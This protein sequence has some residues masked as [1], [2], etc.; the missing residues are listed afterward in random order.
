MKK[1]ISYIIFLISFIILLGSC[2]HDP[3]YTEVPTDPDPVVIIDENGKTCDKDTTY[4]AKDVLPIL[5]GNCAFS[6][7]HGNGSA[8]EGVDL[9]T[10]EKI[11]VTA[12]VNAF[13]PEGS[14]LYEVIT[15]TDPDKVMPPT[16]R[17]SNDQIAI[18]EKWIR[19]GALNNS[20]ND[21][22]TT[23]VTFAKIVEPIIKNSCAGCHGEES[24]RAGISLTNYE[25]IKLQADSGALLGTINHQNGYVA[26]P[27]QQ[28]KLDACKIDQ[29]RIWIENGALNN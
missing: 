27:F 14:E 29:I 19:Q 10:Y 17:L 5:V 16:G 18:I 13:D 6:G 26:M 8:Q 4:F 22:D 7:C 11:I 9:T 1:K 15:E 28:P 21:C 20:C 2:K 25:Q 12:D 24:P 23:A 3:V